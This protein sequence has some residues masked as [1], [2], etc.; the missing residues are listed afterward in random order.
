MWTVY[1]Q[2]EQKH[3][4]DARELQF[5]FPDLYQDLEKG[6]K[7]CRDGGEEWNSMD[8]NRTIF[9]IKPPLTASVGNILSFKDEGDRTLG[10]TVDVE[11]STE[12]VDIVVTNVNSA[13]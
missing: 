3:D 7:K 5:L 4:V 8:S 2:S 11:G 6:R 10:S 1:N 13:S 12:S 9:I